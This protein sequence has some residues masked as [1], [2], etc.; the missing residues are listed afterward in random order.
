MNQPA[1]GNETTRDSIQMRH[2][3]VLA[4]VAVI[5]WWIFFTTARYRFTAIAVRLK[6]EV[7]KKNTF[8]QPAATHATGENTALPPLLSTWRE[9]QKPRH[10]AKNSE[11]MWL[12]TKKLVGVC[13]RWSRR[14]R[15][16]RRPFANTANRRTIV[17][18]T[19]SYNGTSITMSFTASVIVSTVLFILREKSWRGTGAIA[20]ISSRLLLY[21]VSCRRTISFSFS[22]LQN[23]GIYI[24]M[25]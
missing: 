16:I 6:N 12:I 3:M 8:T 15:K 24:Q 21:N 23:T 5:L 22:P 13:I 7:W 18:T 20:I 25:L 14:K 17:T 1:Q 4:L 19:F 10:E 2:M 9:M 11:T